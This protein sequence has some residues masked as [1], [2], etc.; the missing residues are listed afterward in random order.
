MHEVHS[1]FNKTFE[2]KIKDSNRLW[3]QIIGE[4]KI[5]NNVESIK[6]RKMA[7]NT[8]IEESQI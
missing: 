2:Y 3:I 6:I 5:K 4:L 7:M 8:Q 1:F